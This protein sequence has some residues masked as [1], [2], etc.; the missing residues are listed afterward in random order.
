MT[1]AYTGALRCPRCDTAFPES[2]AHA[3]C[4][5][6]A[7]DAVHVMPAPVYDLK[8]LAEL[9]EVDGPGIFRFADLLPLGAG[10]VV[11]L[12]E[13]ATPLLPVSEVGRDFGVSKLWWKDES[14]NPTWSYKD[15]LAAVAVTKAAQDGAETV[16]V[17]STGNHGASIAAY[18]ARA[19]LRCVVLTVASVPQAMKTLMQS[20]GA[21][22]VA[23]E[24]PADRWIV[25][26]AAVQERGWVPM[27]GYVAPPSGSNPFGVD[28]YK[29]LAYELWE[30]TGHNLPDVLVAPLAYGD[31]VAGLVRGFDDLIT[32]GL[33]DRM[34]RVIAAEPYGPLAA[35][36]RGREGL[37]R[38]PEPTVAFSVAATAPTW[39][40]RHAIEVTG[41]SAA[42]AEDEA[43]MNAQRLL[44]ARSGL[45]AEASSALTLAVMPRLLEEGLVDR[46]ERVVLL[47]TSTG[48]KDVGA[49]AAGM[50]AVPTIEPTLESFDRA[51]SRAEVATA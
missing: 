44:A 37:E 47:G 29:T 25:M 4:P 43:I 35:R 50:P 23:L 46:A 24:R 6:C 20:F 32:L 17:S 33:A 39:Q 15:R 19:G 30:Q 3:I 26:R 42:S 31:G 27:S 28:G 1:R 10:P 36:L 11:S 16:V 18:A 2:A 14:R 48:L 12:G 7:H 22:V 49:T 8:G 41:G 51:V 45:Y 40:A 34:P 13:G 9:P 38:P 5:R 21:V